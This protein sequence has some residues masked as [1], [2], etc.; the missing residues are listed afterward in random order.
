[1]GLW[2]DPQ[3]SLVCTEAVS[4]E[5]SV[6]CRLGK[7][8]PSHGPNMRLHDSV[9]GHRIDTGSR[10]CAFP[11]SQDGLSKFPGKKQ[12]ERELQVLACR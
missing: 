6:P 10:L 5:G 1:M 12:T 11:G 9:I 2:E 4:F 3:I 7:S 8:V